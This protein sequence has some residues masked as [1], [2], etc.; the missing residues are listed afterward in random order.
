MDVLKIKA[1]Y[2]H[3]LRKSYLRTKY[4]LRRF[5]SCIIL[6]VFKKNVVFLFLYLK[7]GTAQTWY[8]WLRCLMMLNILRLKRKDHPSA[9]HP[10]SHPH[11]L[12]HSSFWGNQAEE[13][14]LV[15][16]RLKCKG[17]PWALVRLCTC[18]CELGKVEEEKKQM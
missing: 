17:H 9:S 15:W 18:P 2:K 5:F 12:S 1:L 14:L 3:K 6:W 13:I 7:L 8:T 16:K 4:V 10:I 11:L